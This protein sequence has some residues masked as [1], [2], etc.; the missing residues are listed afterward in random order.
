MTRRDASEFG[1]TGGLLGGPSSWRRIVLAGVGGG[2]ALALGAALAA[3]LIGGG[4]GSLDHGLDPTA[5]AP[6]V[7]PDVEQ[8]E[9]TD[10]PV[11]VE[12]DATLPPATEAPPDPTATEEQ[13]PVTP[14]PTPTAV[15]EEPSP[16]P[17]ENGSEGVEV[18]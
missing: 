5:A 11:E 8:P 16:A 3:S 18:P 15:I 14:I 12:P 9:A 4:S 7:F 6:L 2:V 13:A 1:K 17:T 10:L